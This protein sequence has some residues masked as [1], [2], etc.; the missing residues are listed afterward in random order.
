MSAPKSASAEATTESS[1]A[2][3]T[4]I[5]G[6]SNQDQAVLP[7]ASAASSAD[8]LIRQS[9]SVH[10]DPVA[11]FSQPA[12]SLASLQA[13]VVV[14]NEI[15]LGE[16]EQSGAES[17]EVSLAREN[18]YEIDVDGQYAAITDSHEISEQQAAAVDSHE[19]AEQ[20]A[21]RVDAVSDVTDVEEANSHEVS[22]DSVDLAADLATD[23][24]TPEEVQIAQDLGDTFAP[25]SPAERRQQL[26]IDPDAEVQLDP[27]ATIDFPRTLPSST[28][29]VP[30]AYG[31]DWGD[32]FVG[33]AGVAGGDD[34]ARTDGSAAL[35][36]GV[37]DAVRNVG[38]EVGVGIISLDGF[39]DDGIVGFKLHKI[40]PQAGN[41]AVA[42]GWTNP[43]KWGNATDAEDT[44]Y[45]VATKQFRLRPNADNQMP[46]TTSL[47]VGTGTFRSVGA[48]DDD[49]NGVNVFG[50]AGLRVI[51][52]VSLI[53][54]WNG[55]GLGL[56]TSVVP[57]RR[58]PFVLTLGVSDVTGN[59]DEG[60]QFQGSLGYA[61]RF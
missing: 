53:S 46:L 37:G 21:V 45:G 1:L 54:S 52:Q 8:S 35:G 60:A 50:S 34:S 47:G 51:P 18:T 5:K 43:I 55:T 28:F 33:L 44:F 58:L 40:F 42:A 48:I 16:T 22:P 20:Q 4:A 2:D 17:D 56:A 14:R 38:L 39:A 9:L 59:T 29:L 57:V 30:S 24:A 15:E 10:S 26:L 13:S 31:A 12:V 6:L 7:I 32:V 3:Q 61:L 49:E 27:I 41:L 19:I 11:R 23:L 25:V 36:F